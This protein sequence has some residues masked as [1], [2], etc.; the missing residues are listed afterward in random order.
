MKRERVCKLR[1]SAGREF[2]TL[3][4]ED[5]KARASVDLREVI[6]IAK[7]LDSDEEQSVR[8]GT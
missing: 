3:G 8:E 7:S 1:R 5:E 2:Q 4:A 6:G